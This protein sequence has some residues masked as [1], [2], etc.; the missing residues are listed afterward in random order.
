MHTFCE[1][2]LAATSQF[3]RVQV[4]VGVAV[5]SAL[6]AFPTRVELCGGRHNNERKWRYSEKGKTP[7]LNAGLRLE[8]QHDLNS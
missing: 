2:G 4:A 3:Y 6:D 8:R 1:C 7:R 5:G